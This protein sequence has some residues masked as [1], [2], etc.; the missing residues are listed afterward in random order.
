MA[1]IGFSTGSLAKSDVSGALRILESASSSAIEL[2]ALRTHEL[3]P[4]VRSI[5]RLRLDRYDHIS[6]HAPSAFT[7]RQEPEIA[8]ALFPLAQ[9]GWLIVLHPD[10][11][12]DFG[13]WTPFADRLCIENMDR[14]KSTGRTA[15]ELQPV[16]RRLPEASFCF[17]VA[18]AWQCDS[19]MGQAL[20]LLDAFGDRLSEVHVSEL[21]THSR[22]V[23]LSAAG[24]WACRRVASLVPLDVPLIIEAPVRP[25]EICAELEVSLEALGRLVSVPCTA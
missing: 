5:P 20:R 8:A 2:S 18:H 12:H 3:G 15:D 17:D 23:R 7:A 19:S 21:D 4:L 1:G 6:V 14:R 22:H 13:L 9:R 10:T 11:I 25:D 16:F 24:V